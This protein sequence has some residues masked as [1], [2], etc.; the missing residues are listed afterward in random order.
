MADPNGMG[1]GAVMYAALHTPDFNVQSLTQQ[2]PELRKKAV[3]LIDGESPLETVF[4]TNK[5]ARALGIQEAMSRLQAE[6]FAG[7]TVLRRDRERE[8]AGLIILHTILCCFSPRIEA[9]EAHPGTY[10]LDI[11]NMHRLFG[12]SAQLANKLRRRVMAAGFLVNIAVS[13]NF[14]AACCLARGKAG[15]SVIPPQNEAKALGALPISVLDPEPEQAETLASWGI[16]TLAE[17]ASLPEIDL[18][19]RM[20]QSGKFLHALARGEWPHL[21]VPI[22]ADLESRLIEKIELDYPVEMLEPLLFLLARMIDQLLKRAAS[23]SRAIAS[24][25]VILKLERDADGRF[26]VYRRVVRPALPLQD[27]RTLLKLVQLDLETHPPKAA[28]IGLELRAQSAKPHRAQHGLFL[29]QSPEPGSL[30]VLLARLRKLLGNE[31][32]GS[33][34]LLDENRRDAFHMTPFSPLC[35]KLQQR[36]ASRSTALRIYRPPQSIGVLLNGTAPEHVFWN[37]QKYVVVEHAGPWRL[38]G[39]W[40]SESTWNGEQWDVKLENGSSIQTCR[41]ERDPNSNCWCVQGT[42]D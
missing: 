29:P 17:L 38:S 27:Q 30:E 22:E 12:D 15:I 6:S 16:R 1:K 32:V 3:A 13:Q 4:A 34:E 31:R 10:V 8:E 5:Q 9:I 23:H 41:I 18:V 26:Q 33:P 19:S 2:R 40:W 7:A 35:T 37:G 39:Q 20:G 21:M 14:H 11:Q 36:P 24:L 42:Y 25:Q 28:I